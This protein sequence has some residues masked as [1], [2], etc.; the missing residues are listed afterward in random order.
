M[1]IK[2]AVVT[3]ATN[4]L[5]GLLVQ[6]WPSLCH[7]TPGEDTLFRRGVTERVSELDYGLIRK[8]L[9][10]GHFCTPGIELELACNRE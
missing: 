10:I 9:R 7:A 8:Q 2:R 1:N 5:L 4:E 6:F 3:N